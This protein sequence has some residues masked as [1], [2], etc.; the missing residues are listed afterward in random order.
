MDQTKLNKLLEVAEQ[1]DQVKLRVLHNAVISCVREYKDDSTAAKLK[2]WKSAE[3]ALD[4]FADNLWKKH[5]GNDSQ[6]LANLVAVVDWLT[7][8]GWKIKKQRFILTQKGENITGIRWQLQYRKCAK[9]CLC[10]FTAA[11]VC[12]HL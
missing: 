4:E 12:R 8:N 3:A 6:T 7:A 11:R 10:I 5:F 9:V 1:Q 2:D